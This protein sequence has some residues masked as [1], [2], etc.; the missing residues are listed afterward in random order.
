MKLYEKPDP[1]RY[2]NTQTR[3]DPKPEK[4]LPVAALLA[5][6]SI[7]QRMHT[8][9]SKKIKLKFP[10]TY[11]K[12]LCTLLLTWL[13]ILMNNIN[14]YISF[15][16]LQNGRLV[17]FNLWLQPPFF[18][19]QTTFTLTSIAPMPPNLVFWSMIQLCCG[20]DLSLINK[21]HQ[22]CW[23]I[24]GSHLQHC[25]SGGYETWSGIC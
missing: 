12:Y 10:G 11:L 17:Q 16:F 4:V 21:A 15:I 3:P 22:M 7:L 8:E 24:R 14:M 23:P 6:K 9:I 2:P 18:T 25:L 19:Q 13:L 5:K 1:T 20:L